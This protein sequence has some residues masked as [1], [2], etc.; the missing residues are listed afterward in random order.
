MAKPYQIKI[1]LDPELMLQDIQPLGLVQRGIYVTVL[2]RLALGQTIT[3]SNTRRLRSLLGGAR[4]TTTERLRQSWKG[5]LDRGVFQVAEDYVLKS[6][7]RAR[8]I[9]KRLVKQKIARGAATRG[10][11]HIEQMVEHSLASRRKKGMIR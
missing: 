4:G 3:A 2:C 1:P 7:V 11:Q 9:R 10:H 5:L 6:R 8:R